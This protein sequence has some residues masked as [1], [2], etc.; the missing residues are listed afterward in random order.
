MKE[1]TFLILFFVCFSCKKENSDYT[2]PREKQII[3][4]WYITPYG[5]PSDSFR[6]LFTS[7]NDTFNYFVAGSVSPTIIIR[8]LLESTTYIVHYKDSVGVEQTLTHVT[9]T[10]NI[11]FDDSLRATIY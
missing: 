6:Y 11:H 2:R 9:S 5:Q 8:K 3:G 7:S 1:F 10:G 4:S